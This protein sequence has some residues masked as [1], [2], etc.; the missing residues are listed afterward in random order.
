MHSKLRSAGWQFLMSEFRIYLSVVS[1]VQPHS[2]SA[3]KSFSWYH[4]WTLGCRDRAE[5]RTLADALLAGA[6]TSL[7]HLLFA[8]D[9][10]TSLIECTKHKANT[11]T[12]NCSWNVG[13]LQRWPPL[14]FLYWF[15]APPTVLP[16]SDLDWHLYLIQSEFK[17]PYFIYSKNSGRF[18]YQFE[19]KAC[20]DEGFDLPVLKCAV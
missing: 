19:Y 10:P 15:K 4:K 11:F 16:N 6:K 14:L 9:V 1:V 3:I 8:L 5:K 17:V 20:W 18:F 13:K 12:C 2:S 7:A